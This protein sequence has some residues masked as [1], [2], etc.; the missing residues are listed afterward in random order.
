MPGCRLLILDDDPVI[1][2]TIQLVAEAAGAQARLCTEAPAFF[3][4]LAEWRP[5]HI[6]T[7]LNMPEMDGLQVLSELARV[8]CRAHVIVSSGVGRRVLEAAARAGTEQGLAMAG[9][10]PKPFAP[11]ALRQLL[12][13]PA[14]VS[15]GTDTGADAD[16]QPTLADLQQAL[17]RH[18]LRVVFQPKVHCASGQLS[19]VETL[20]RWQHPVRGTICPDRFIGLAESGG[21]I[22]ALT[23]QVLALA[24]ARFAPWRRDGPGRQGL[25]LALNMS[26]NV[27]ENPALVGQ[28]RN[29]CLAAGVDPSSIIFELT[30]TGMRDP[31]LALQLTTRLRVQGFELSIDDFGIGYSSMKELARLP[32]SEMKV[33]REFVMSAAQSDE[34]RKIIRAIVGLGHGL[35][36]RVTAEGVEDEVALAYLRE[37][38][39]DDAQGYLIARPMPAEAFE[40]WAA[41]RQPGGEAERLLAVKALHLSEQVSQPRFERLVLLAQR[42]LHMPMAMINIVGAGRQWSLATAGVPA[43]DLP[44]E[45]SM[46]VHAV[47]AAQP[48]FVD[49]LRQDVRFAGLPSVLGR[50]GLRAYASVPLRVAGGAPLGTLCVLDTTPHDFDAGTRSLL[51]GLGSMA[52]AEL[53]ADAATLVDEE[54]GL[55][56]QRAFD[57]RAASTLRWLGE[58]GLPASLLLMGLPAEQAEGGHGPAAGPSH[59]ARR[60]ISRFAALLGP[61]ALLAR[62]GS[63]QAVA[64]LPGVDDSTAQDALHRLADSLADGADWLRHCGWST[65]A[66]GAVGS[67]LQRLLADADSRRQF[68][69]TI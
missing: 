16:W 40:A 50:A 55:W 46:C 39:C 63:H 30:E 58:A 2:L 54:T 45:E 23:L 10:L 21:L 6:C 57:E 56:T 52:E 68:P 62:H 14:G 69:P 49:D 19:G 43:T 22:D 65:A 20:V 44:L 28:L 15:A 53:G 33:D 9:V 59:F 35:G 17:D 26:R 27:L 48:M 47:R 1:G 37:V 42:G 60:T 34:S 31:A 61:G 11:A 8:G 24:L 13:R 36:L 38:G 67:D 51:A 25:K 18:D 5:S 66:S 29:P 41:A 32:F 4:A 7:D 12:Q 3:A 64:L